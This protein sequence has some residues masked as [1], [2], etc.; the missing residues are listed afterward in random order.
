MQEDILIIHF[1]IYQHFW[2]YIKSFNKS[3]GCRACLSESKKISGRNSFIRY[4]QKSIFLEDR[5]LSL[6]RVLSITLIP[7][8]CTLFE[9]EDLCYITTL[10]ALQVQHYQSITSFSHAQLQYSELPQISFGKFW[11]FRCLF[12]KWY[13]LSCYIEFL[14]SLAIRLNSRDFLFHANFESVNIFLSFLHQ[15]DSFVIDTHNHTDHNRMRLH[16][17]CHHFVVSIDFKFFV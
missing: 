14:H 8:L 15:F 5:T 13:Q 6:W 12:E 7:L 17:G 3:T 1:I 10:L 4:L 11:V 9:N 16:F 2:N